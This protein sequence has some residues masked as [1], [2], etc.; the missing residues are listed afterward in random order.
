[1]ITADDVAA[2]VAGAAATPMALSVTGVTKRYKSGFTLDDI[3]LDLPA[4]YIMG[5]IGPN[6]AGKSTLIK[7]I[8]NM[9]RRDAGEIR[10]F[11]R[12]NRRDEEYVKDRIGV[13][14]DSSYFIETWTVGVAEKA[15]ATMYSTW[16]HAA[17]DGYLA[18]FGLDRR[19]KIKELSRG[20][21]M[22]LML[23]VALSHEASLLIL[24][25]PTSGLDVLAR[26]EL[27]DIL[28]HYIEDGR[29]SVLFSTHITADLERA[30]DFITYI[31]RG[32]LYFTG[33]TS[34]LEESFRL[35]KGGPG[36]LDAVRR[37]AVGVHRY[38]TG[39]DAL[40]RT[41]DFARLAADG[42]AG[43]VSSLSVEPASIDDI[44]RLTNVRAGSGQEA[45]R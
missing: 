39:F 37:A 42:V 3:T 11:G 45:A 20:M 43:P 34:E 30:S 2:T 27:M 38:E 24:D 21:Q 9:I 12:D 6:G 16:D 7:L 28:Q 44:I 31:T 35:V 4:G 33:P 1:M 13:V 26:D 29:R 18:G 19:K 32:R 40:V 22:K 8:L 41:D 23:A 25:E 14:F 36:E 5:L 17:F 10:I 15:M